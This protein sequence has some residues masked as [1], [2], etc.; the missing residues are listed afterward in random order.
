LALHLGRR[1]IS[2]ALA[3]DY[4]KSYPGTTIK[5]YLQK[6]DAEENSFPPYLRGELSQKLGSST[7]GYKMDLLTATKMNSK[8]LKQKSSLAFQVIGFLSILHHDAL[9]TD[10]IKEWLKTSKNNI[11]T[12]E[13]VGEFLCKK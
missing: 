6:Y 10:T 12:M 3:I 8:E 2:L 1:P 9:S 7:D 5:E 11:D 4:I 13:L